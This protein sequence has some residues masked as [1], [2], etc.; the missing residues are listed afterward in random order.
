MRIQRRKQD[1][2]L[3][4]EDRLEFVLEAQ[5]RFRRVAGR[6]EKEKKKLVAG[7]KAFRER[8][9]ETRTEER[10]VCGQLMLLSTAYNRVKPNYAFLPVKELTK[11]N[12]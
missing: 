9:T 12:I 2:S 6:R 7:R 5:G 10:D 4:D 8:P 1:R 3:V 11:G